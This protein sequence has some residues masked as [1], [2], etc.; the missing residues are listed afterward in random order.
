MNQEGSEIMK[1]TSRLTISLTP[2]IDKKIIELR[3][4]DAF[5]RCSLAEIIRYLI[6]AGIASENTN[7]PGPSR[8]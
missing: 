3:K 1:K 2:E 5:C 4:T 8:R 7:P 6:T